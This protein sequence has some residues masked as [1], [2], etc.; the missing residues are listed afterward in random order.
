MINKKK[1]K[2]I[3]NEN[4]K[5]KE[6]QEAKKLLKAFKKSHHGKVLISDY[7]Y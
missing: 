7:R 2:P 6:I 4:S 3:V 1:K 5:Q